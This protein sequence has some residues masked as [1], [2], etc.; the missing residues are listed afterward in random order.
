[1]DFEFYR[2]F[3]VIAEAGNITRAS[4]EL[5]IVPNALSNQVKKL[6][7]VYGV[8]LLKLQQGKKNIE[9][10]PAGIAFLQ[11]AK[12]ICKTEDE[13]VMSMQN[14]SGSIAGS[15]NFG[16]SN[17]RSEY[18]LEKYIIPFIKLHPEI[19]YKFN[20]MT[21]D[22]QIESLR[23]GNLD[24]SFSNAAIPYFPDFAIIDLGRENFYVIYHKDTPVPWKD[25][26]T[27][28]PAHLHNLQLCGN[29]M[30]FRTLHN[31]CKEQKIKFKINYIAN[32]VNS[33]ISLIASLPV[34]GVMAGMEDDTIPENLVRK[35]IMDNSLHFEQTFFWN[36]NRQLNSAASIFLKYFLE[37]HGK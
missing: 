15:I 19:N 2:N 8:Q 14:F 27:I 33:S 13:L 3:C 22:K 23:S 20:V 37:H 4:K 1:M 9:L 6:E 16:A 25:D 34:I 29:D 31:V 32:T 30:H 17:S 28:I 21:T 12:E 7:Q 36:K 24:F 11:K 18:Y 5:N 10:T 35:Q 26:E